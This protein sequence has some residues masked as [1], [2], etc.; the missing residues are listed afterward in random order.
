MTAASRPQI[1]PRPLRRP[2]GDVGGELV[3]AE[4][5]GGDPRR[6]SIR[7]SRIEH[8]HHRQHQ[9][10]V[11]ARQRL[12]ELV[13]GVGGDRADRVDHDELGAVGAGGLDRRPQVAVGEPGVGAPQQDQPAV[14]QLERVERRGRCRWSSARRAPTVGPQ[15]ARTSRLAPRWWK[16]R[17]SRPMIDSR[18]WLPA[19]LNGRT[20]SAPCSAITACSRAAISASASSHEICSNSPA[21]F[22]PDAAQRV[23]DPVRAVHAVEEAVDLRAQLALA[24]RVVGAA[25]E[26]HGH[27]RR[28]TVTSHPHE[29]GQSWWQ[30]PW[31]TLGVGHRA[32]ATRSA[33]V[34]FRG[35]F[36]GGVATGPA[37]SGGCRPSGARRGRCDEVAQI[38]AAAHRAGRRVKV[39][40]AGHSFTAA[41]ATDGRAAHAR[42]PRP[43]RRRRPRARPGHGRGRDPPPPPQRR[44]RRGRAGACPTSATSTASR[45]PARSPP[46]PTAPGSTLGNLA[47]TVVGMQLVTGTGEVVR[48]DADVE[49]ELLRVGP[50]RPRRPRRRHRGHAPVRAG[51]RPP[52]PRDRGGPRRRARRVRRPRRR[53]RPLRAVLDA[54][55]PP[56]PGQAQLAD[57]RAAG[58]RSR[59]GPTCGTSGSAENLGFGAGAAGSGGASRR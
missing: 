21:P 28:S 36:S 45:S 2:V 27:A 41:A 56:L 37:T 38:V 30:V 50:G 39:I 7:P 4:R 51:V 19:S 16:K 3:E 8:V 35:V 42:P 24:E 34:R 11:G 53:R 44:A 31:I 57:R 48:C 9:G 17:P 25:A 13:G 14:A 5:V 47:T 58:A 43:G 54:R 32:H 18:L 33:A 23:E 49:P 1:A 6:V 22:G 52:R 12:D 15:I 59:G 55:H 29:S 10:D 20:A 26:L 46:P 40:G